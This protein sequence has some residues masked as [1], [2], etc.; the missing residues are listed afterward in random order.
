MT[1]APT[2]GEVLPKAIAPEGL[3][4]ATPV[5]VMAK[6]MADKAKEGQAKEA[7]ELARNVPIKGV[8]QKIEEI[9]VERDP[10]SGAKAR[11]AAEQTRYDEAK[12]QAKLTKDYLEHGYEGLPAVD[13]TELRKKVLAEA[14]TRPDLK[15]ELDG[16]SPAEKKA[17]AENRLRD[18]RHA[19]FGKEIMQEIIDSDNLADSVTPAKLERDKIDIRKGVSGD[20]ITDVNQ[21]VTIIDHQL[22]EF[23]RSDPDSNNWGDMAKKIRDLEADMPTIAKELTTKERELRDKKLELKKYE[24][25]VKNRAAGTPLLPGTDAEIN[26][27]I[28]TV[29]GEINTKQ[30]EI[31]DNKAKIQTLKDIK[32]NEKSLREQRKTLVDEKAD[33]ET[34]DREIDLELQAAQINYHD[35]KALRAAQEQALVEDFQFVI[36]NSTS[37][38]INDDVEKLGVLYDEELKTLIETEDYDRDRHLLQ[39]IDSRYWEA[40]KRGRRKVKKDVLNTD[41]EDLMINGPESFM[42]RCLNGTRKPDGTNYSANEIKDLLKDSDFREKFQSRM[43]KQVLFAKFRTG[44]MRPEDLDIVGT[45]SWGENFI[46]EALNMNKQARD[47]IEQAFGEGALEKPNFV[48]RMLQSVKQNKKMYFWLL[49]GII[50]LPIA[51]AVTADQMKPKDVELEFNTLKPQ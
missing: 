36:G 5:E 15:I 46:Q 42:V 34:K 11:T 39:R 48:H 41:Y 33:L 16:K 43:I 3:T 22:Q 30:D 1:S 19:T 2:P 35:A 17:W 10:N 14:Q 26:N 9:G 45:S 40:G 23:D 44:G 24:D 4:G 28:T 31:D 47:R 8:E 27:H 20:L 12:K 32:S 13:Q 21:R 7:L 18:P 6:K 49:A 38:L 37:E 50:G 51:M 25:E 29:Q